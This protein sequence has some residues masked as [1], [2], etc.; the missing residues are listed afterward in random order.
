MSTH[1]DHYRAHT[2]EQKW[3]VIERLY[4]LWLEHPEYRLG[5]LIANIYKDPYNVEDFDLIATLER[6]Y[7]EMEK[8]KK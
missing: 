1:S 7:S 4:T 8:A 6:R 3:E 2:P 5:Q